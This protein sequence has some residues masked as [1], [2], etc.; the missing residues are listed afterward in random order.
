MLMPNWDESVWDA[1]N[2]DTPSPPPISLLPVK[3]KKT[4]PR[5]MAGNP[6]P[7]DDA[8]LL[9]LAED[10]ADGCAAHEVTIGIKQNTEAVLRAAIAAVVAAKQVLG[11][12]NDLVSGRSVTLAAADDAGAVV[13]RNCRLRL[14]K[15]FGGQAYSAGWQE[16]GFP[17]GSTAVP[18]S[19]NARFS[20]LATLAAYFTAHPTAESADME[21]TAAICTAAHTAI[22]D[23]RASLNAGESDQTT[24]EKA[25]DAALRTLRKRV[26][27][28]IDE[29]GTLLADDDGRY[30]AF[31]LN[32]PATP[33]APVAIASLT[34]TALGGG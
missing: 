5:I 4:N 8:V 7:D 6:T 16:A 9:A 29:L 24:A 22:S 32:I 21:A 10:L 14:I 11:A 31:G 12:A 3:K 18:A 23:A 13:I 30:E 33:V 28:L 2:W 20:L 34:L 25:E 1:G 27:G 19:R 15:V 17:D 26:R